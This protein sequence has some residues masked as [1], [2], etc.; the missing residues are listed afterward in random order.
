MM[1]KFFGNIEWG[2]LPTVFALALPTM[3]EQLMHT[4]VQYVDTAMVGSL[5]TQAS[6]AV[7]STS[8]VGWL[9]GS[10]LSALAI[11]FLAYIAREYGAQRYENASLAAA[12]SV[13]ACLVSGAAFMALALGLSKMASDTQIDTL[14]LDEGFGTLD[15]DTLAQA[16]QALSRIAEN[17]RL[18][19]R[20]A[21][22]AGAVLFHAA[23]IGRDKVLID[24]G[25]H[26]VVDQNCVVRPAIDPGGFLQSIINGHLASLSPRNNGSDL[27][28]SVSVFEFLHIGNPFLDAD[29]HDSVDLRMGIEHFYGMYDDR[30]AVYKKELLGLILGVHPLA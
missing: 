29:H 16:M 6:A 3:L 20:S 26:S 13:L 2:L 22:D 17:D 21:A 18:V 12:Q 24:Q 11:G 15:E 27:L 4:A 14:F 28:Q 25:A 10:S 23:E 19:G 9:V 1:K 8:T 7:G 5:G 30:L